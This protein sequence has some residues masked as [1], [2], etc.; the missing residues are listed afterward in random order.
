[1]ID[2]DTLAAYLEDALDAEARA[3]IQAQL[4]SEPEALRYVLE[5]RKLD[6]LLRSMLRPETQK[7]RVKQSILAA[8]GGIG[9][10][11]LKARVLEETVSPQAAQREPGTTRP[12]APSPLRRFIQSWREFFSVGGRI[13]RKERRDHKEELQFPQFL[14]SL[15][16]LRLI[17]QLPLTASAIRRFAF[18]AAAAVL[19]GVGLFFYFTAA[20][21]PR[22]EI[23]HFAAVVGSPKVRHAGQH[24]SLDASLS[25]TVWLGDRIETGDADKTEIQ[26]KDGT[27]LR[28]NFNTTIEIPKSKVRSVK[29]I[30]TPK[31][32]PAWPLA[33]SRPPE[34]KLLLGQVWAKVQKTTS[35]SQFAV[36]TPVATAAVKGTEFGLKV[37]KTHPSTL[38][39]Q[40]STRLVA[41]LT[42]KEGAVEFFNAFGK[43]E[44]TALTESQASA[45]TAPTEPKRIASLK[46]F[47]LTTRYLAVTNPKLILHDAFEDLVYPAGWIGINLAG[48]SQGEP[49]A[50][51]GPLQRSNAA[52]I[53][54]VWRGSP[55]EQAGLQV[56][57]VISAVNGQPVTNQWQVRA[58]ILSSLHQPITLSLQRA[59]QERAVALTPTAPSNAPALPGVPA[60]VQKQ[61]FDATWQLIAPGPRQRIAP[62]QTAAGQIALERLL[63][64]FPDCAAVRYNLAFLHE[65][66]EEMGEAIRHYRRAVELDPPVA[67]YHFSLGLALRSIGNFDRALQELEEAA[68]L[69]PAWW[70]SAHWLA[71]AYTLVERYADAVNAVDAGL[72]LNPL[73]ADLF[74]QKAEVLLRA[75]QTDAALPAA[76]KAVELEP[77]HATARTVLGKVYLELGRVDDAEAAFRKAI[78]LGPSDN[79]AH[80]D[81]ATLLRERGLRLDEAEALYRKALEIEPDDAVALDGLGIVLGLRGQFAEAER[82][83]RKAL[84]I[85]PGSS[86]ANNN[87]GE[88]LRNQ[89]RLDE[90]E[91]Q[92]RKALEIDP[93][94]LGCCMNLGIL[95]AMRR[96]FAEAEK[97]F[98]AVLERAPAS[99]KLQTYV[100]LASVC[101]DQ[102]K[103]EEAEQ[104]F[105]QALA[106]SPD[107]PHV[108]NGFAW[109]LAEHRL[110]LDE[111]LALSRRAVQAAPKDA[112]DL[113]T[114]GWVHF[115]RG[116]L[117]DAEAT[118]KKALELAGDNPPAAEIREHLKQLVEK[119]GTPPK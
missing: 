10:A 71:D 55:A 60:N 111:A 57:D 7:Q 23:G 40:P 90:A 17:P 107:E 34:V 85:E 38:N 28:L 49:A 45:D 87:L 101:G 61:L 108:C 117:A 74:A 62:G 104:F 83:Y 100:N 79:S 78:A 98:R 69:A 72:R 2:R 93:D 8:V 47:R 58:A 99:I 37:Q 97:M 5:Q 109:F 63:G 50:A 27:T 92:Y 44:A 14:R 22:I 11:Q 35:Q 25:T 41:V 67:L 46:T 19:L 18:G 48:E 96:Q 110:K 70:L 30:R 102:G 59:G 86:A 4:A 1:M 6:R 39:S 118:L 106:M 33:L 13:S 119:K 95:H 24:S 76:L 52:R 75:R 43:V 80:V 65:A 42:V 77:A 53:S 73:S 82:M 68:R 66:K 16:S 94:N 103:V 116:E 89:G 20:Q 114:L 21:G 56:G 64:S 105:R 81:L 113:D 9:P 32:A 26:F 31:S 115:Q 54:R 51:G 84:E 112:N 88:L 3:Q 91:R 29:E 15:R 12:I 36:Q